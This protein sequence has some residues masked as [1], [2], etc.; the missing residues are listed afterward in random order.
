MVETRNGHDFTGEWSEWGQFRYHGGAGDIS[1]INPAVEA[2][3]GYD[4]ANLEQLSTEARIQRGASATAAIA[5]NTAGA[6]SAAGRLAT[7]FPRELPTTGRLAGAAGAYKP[8]FRA[9]SDA[10]IAGGPFK[11]F[12]KWGRGTVKWG[13]GAKDA[14][15]RAAGITAQEAKALD[16]AMVR[17]AQQFYDGI[18]KQFPGNAAAKARVD[19][20][21][22]ILELQG[23]K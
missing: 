17:A 12:P 2:I 15:A 9:P 4:L 13:T 3:G 5:G 1:G 8:L 19:L 20:M 7:A 11:D 22:R 18:F 21:A 10:R 14:A 16:P 6:L 23:A